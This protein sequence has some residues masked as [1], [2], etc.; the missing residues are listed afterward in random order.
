MCI[1]HQ[2]DPDR[3]RLVLGHNL[4]LE[5]SDGIGDELRVQVEPDCGDVAGLCL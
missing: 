1:D 5:L 4:A 2:V 3:L